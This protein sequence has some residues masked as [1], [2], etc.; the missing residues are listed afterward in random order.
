M[1]R[2]AAKPQPKLGKR[3]FIIDEPNPL[4]E[5][6]NSKSGIPIFGTLGLRGSAIGFIL[7]PE[8]RGRYV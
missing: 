3:E 5:I 4:R 7:D 1:R 6:R 8:L 2:R